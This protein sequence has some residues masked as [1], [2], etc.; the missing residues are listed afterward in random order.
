QGTHYLCKGS[1]LY[2]NGPWDEDLLWLFGP[3]AMKSTVSVKERA[4]FEAGIGGYYTLRGN[5]GFA[6][7][8]CAG[9]R[10][11]PSQ[12]DMLHADLWWHGQNVAVDAGTY[13]YN[14]PEPW[15]NPLA[16]TAFH[17]TVTADDLDQMD[18]A[19]K[20]LWLPWLRGRVRCV[21]R[22]VE[23]HLA[24]FEGEHD[25]YRRLKSPV[26]HRR[27]ILRLPEGSWLVLDRLTSEGDH[28]YR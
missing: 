28:G 6:F 14:A 12:A 4:D 3:R 11:R 9:F 19:G 26:T 13:S 2:A 21:E 18:R 15:N 27:A 20:F 17:N 1:R 16:H 10:H 23:G 5:N 25:G 22:S 24:Y 7:V 8:R